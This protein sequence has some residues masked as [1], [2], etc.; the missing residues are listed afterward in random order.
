VRVVN[1]AVSAATFERISAATA[2]PSINR[3][4]INQRS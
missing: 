2:L 1:A 3:A 4:D